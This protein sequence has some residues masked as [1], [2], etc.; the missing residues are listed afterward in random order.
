LAASSSGIP[1]QG[2]DSIS[3]PNEAGKITRSRD[4][5]VMRNIPTIYTEVT[6]LEVCTSD[7]PPK[8]ASGS[9]K[10]VGWKPIALAYDNKE[11]MVKVDFCMLPL[12][13]PKLYR[14]VLQY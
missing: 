13:G 10:P 8:T 12:S 3:H 1:C 9:S 2:D 6:S 4:L 5:Q 7:I 14:E 11:P